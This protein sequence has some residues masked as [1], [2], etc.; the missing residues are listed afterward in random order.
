MNFYLFRNSFV[1]LKNVKRV[2]CTERA[3]QSAIR[4]GVRVSYFGGETSELENLTIEEQEKIFKEI[5]NIL[6][7]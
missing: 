5:C 2:D 3:N 7:K 4:F 1:S 6:S